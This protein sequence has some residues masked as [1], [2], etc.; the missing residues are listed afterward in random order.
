[1]GI[2]ASGGSSAT[3]LKISNKREH[4]Q[5]KVNILGRYAK[6]T[7]LEISTAKTMIMRW[8]SPTSGKI[9]V[10]REELEDVI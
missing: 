6:M 4:I 5:T 1:M 10:D 9:Q 8:N 7:G 2:L 3:F